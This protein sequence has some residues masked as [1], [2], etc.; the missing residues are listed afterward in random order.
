M[1]RL[2]AGFLVLAASDSHQALL[3]LLCLLAGI[4]SLHHLLEGKL[5]RTEYLERKGKGGEMKKQ[6]INE[7]HFSALQG[8]STHWRFHSNPGAGSVERK[9]RLE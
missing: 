8:K 2:S 7:S 1:H 4:E 5:N 3:L 9:Q 6:V